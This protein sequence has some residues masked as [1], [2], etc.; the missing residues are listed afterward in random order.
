M[1]NRN[2]Q[3]LISVVMSV[4]NGEKYLKES[5]ESILK[6]NYKEFEFIII[7]DGSK[8]DSS[9][10]IKKYKKKD[11]R[12]ILIEND[13]NKGLIYSLNRGL[14]L[15]KGKYIARMDADDISEKNRFFEQVNFLEEHKEIAMCGTYI[16]MFKDN[17]KF[18]SKKFVSETEAEKVKTILLFKNYIA[19]PTIMI[20]RE[21]IEKYKLKYN[22]D[23]K[24]MEDYGLWL[25]LSKYEKI[26][27]VPKYLLKYRF[28]GNSIS[29][30]TLEDIE[31]H[32]KKLKNIYLREFSN[33]FK[34]FSNKKL[35]IH[36]EIVLA[37]NLKEYKYTLEEKK[38]YLNILKKEFVEKYN[39]RLLELEIET[40]NQLENCYIYQKKLFDIITENKVKIKLSKI[41]KNKIIRIIKKIVR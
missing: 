5:I 27:I 12:I 19:H 32:K 20:R 41:L 28:L 37:S 33:F 21:T 8:D 13:G 6:Q 4:Y 10:I 17:F 34:D 24:G 35:D 15:C 14:D 36:I 26:E 18:L 3:P 16:K 2:S 29:S 25:Y 40:K 1:V 11:D 38:E 30:K 39:Y 22:L 9:K 7:N 31:N 23:D